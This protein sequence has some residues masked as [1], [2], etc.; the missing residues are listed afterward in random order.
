MSTWSGPNLPT[1]TLTFLFTDVEGSSEPWETQPQAMRQAMARHDALL[2]AVF[3]QHD[4]VVVRPRGEG[5]SLFVVFIRASD[6]IAAVLAGQR[7]L[8]AEDWGEIGPLRVR[9]AMHTGEADLREGDYYGSALNRLARIRSAGSGGQILLS[10]ATAKLVRGALPAGA[11]LQALGS[12][13]L[14]GQREPELLFQLNA[15][16]RPTTFPP[17][18]TLDARPNNLPLQLTSFI[19]REQE[20]TDLGRLLETARLLTLTGPGGSGKTRLALASAAQALDG[21]PDGVWFV[22]LSSVADPAGVVPAIALVLGV[23]ESEGRSLAVSLAAYLRSKQLLLVLDNFEQV[24]EAALVLHD[25]LLE[26]PSLSLLVTS[27][28]LLHLEGEREYAVAP[29]PLPDPTM[30]ATTAAVEQ[31]PAVQLFVEW[32]QALG[33]GFA[34]T[35]ANAA[36]VAEICRRL[37]GLPLAIELAAARVKLLPP[38]ALLARLEQR[39]PLLTGGARSLPARQQTLRNTIQW[40]WD[41]LAPAEQTLFR[42]LAVFTGGWT[43]DAA[44]AVCNPE[45]ELE[46][47][48]GLESLV[49]KSLVQQEERD[50]EPRFSMLATLREFALD[51]L[52]ACGEAE[53]LQRRHAGYYTALAEQADSAF[54][55]SGHLVRDLREPLDPERDNL[56]AALAWALAHGEA[57]LGLR[58]GGALRSWF[59]LRGPGQGLRWLEALLALP[60]A[61]APSRARGLGLAAAGMCAVALSELEVGVPYLEEAAACFRA[62]EDLPRLSSVLTLLGVF[63]PRDQDAR[64]LRTAEEALALARITSERVRIAQA[65]TQLGRTLIHR[66]GNLAVARAHLVEGLRLGRA[67]GAD[68][69]TA[70]ALGH[71]GTLLA[72][73]GERDEAQRLLQEARAQSEAIGDRAGT[74]VFSMYLAMVLNEAGDRARAIAAWRTALVQICELGNSFMLGNSLTGIAM[75]LAAGGQGDQ[76]A[77]LLGAAASSYAGRSTWPL[78][79]WPTQH[80]T[81][82]A[83]TQVALSPEAFARAWAEG[84]ALSLDEATEL[85]FAALSDLTASE[86]VDSAAPA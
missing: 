36:A 63:L 1:G 86:A 7:A 37:D 81:A 19:G 61:A 72:A 52:T 29:L 58:L 35:A 66:D 25:L 53:D 32:A 2:T 26:A 47:L 39:L 56:V 79:R 42:R 22:D 31:N 48:G 12:H 69:V 51:Q 21:F 30:D 76:A 78:G 24:V 17:L 20:L 14:S 27:R 70:G 23:R 80:Q 28:V 75:L 15:P 73:Q 4:G 54:W 64:A 41:L 71:L 16:D 55:Q 18:K 68:S 49:D 85:A 44:E 82:V 60:G 13:R 57:E 62:V 77:R 3:E 8:A 40:S 9:M 74:A 45:G 84:E 83:T 50:G 43:L 11:S 33:S 10:E 46:V 5:D 34:L 67:L 65:E 59:Y 6:A 38:T